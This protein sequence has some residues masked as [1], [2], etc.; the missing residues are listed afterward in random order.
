MPPTLSQNSGRSTSTGQPDPREPPDVW[1]PSDDRRLSVGRVSGQGPCIPHL[2]LHGP[3]L[4][5][6]LHLLLVRV[7]IGLAHLRDRALLIQVGSTPRERLRPL[8]RRSLWIQDVL[9]EKNIKTPSWAA[10]SRPPHGEDCYL[11]YHPLLIV[12]RVS[13][14][15]YSRI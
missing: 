6:L 9:A 15:M 14:L 7:S 13:S 4:Y 1:Y 12:D 10:P 2:P 8:R 5:I 11:L 3:R